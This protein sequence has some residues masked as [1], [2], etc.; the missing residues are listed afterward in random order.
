MTIAV[1]AGSF[2]PVTN[3][4]LDIIRQ[5]SEVF[6]EVIVLLAYNSEKSAFLSEEDRMHLIKESIREFPNVRADMFE[7]LTVDYAK[8]KGASI[9]VRGLRNS[10]DFEYENQMAQINRELNNSIK[11]VFFTPKPENNFVSSSMV[12]EIVVNGGDISKFVPACVSE[13]FN[14]DI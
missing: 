14:C 3:G 13:F 9:L 12:R 1:Y 5:A 10:A 7:G 8:E 11:T 4:H 2:D 6:D